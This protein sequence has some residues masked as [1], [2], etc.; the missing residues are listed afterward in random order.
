MKALPMAK[1]IQM[2]IEYNLPPLKREGYKKVILT[3]NVYSSTRNQLLFKK[4]TEGVIVP[5]WQQGVYEKFRQFHIWI[6]KGLYWNNGLGISRLD[7]VYDFFPYYIDN[8]GKGQLS[9]W[10]AHVS[11]FDFRYI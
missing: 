2:G 3:R 10:H 11:Y 4:G 8:D 5:L 6:S 7:K 9:H 1:P